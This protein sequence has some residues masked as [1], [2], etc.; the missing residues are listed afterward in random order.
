MSNKMPEVLDKRLVDRFVQRGMLKRTEVN[1]VLEKLPDL[2]GQA[3]DISHL[4]F[5][6]A[7]APVE[8][9]IEAVAAVGTDAVDGLAEGVETMRAATIVPV[10]SPEP[11]APS[12]SESTGFG[13]F[14][15]EG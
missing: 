13:S 8:E 9:N 3:D 12:A 14:G 2:D 5:D 15:S 4:V 10:D 1:A 11:A 7:E 6:G